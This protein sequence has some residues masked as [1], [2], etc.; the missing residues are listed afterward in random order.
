[1]IKS[2]QHIN[3]NPSKALIYW[4]LTIVSLIWNLSLAQNIH[5]SHEELLKSNLSPY[6]NPTPEISTSDTSKANVDSLFYWK[7]TTGY[8]NVAIDPGDI[9]A[10]I[11][12]AD[13]EYEIFAWYPYWFPDYHKKFDFS[14]VNTVSYF[15]YRFYPESGKKKTS[16]DW[17]STPMV[18]KAKAAGCKVLL[19]VSSFGKNSNATFLNNEES[20]STLINELVEE[21][22]LRDADGVC[23]D[24]ENIRYQE[25]DEFADFVKKL[26]N[27]LRRA[28]GDALVYLALPSVDHSVSF[29]LAMN[30]DVDRAVIMAYG[31][32]GS[33]SEPKP[34]A[35]VNS[36]GH[37]LT[38]TVDYYT[39]LIEPSKV[40][41]GLPLYGC[42][43]DVREDSLRGT[44]SEFEGYR[45]LSYINNNLSGPATIDSL[46]K[47]SYIEFPLATD[48]N[49]TRK[50]WFNN[51]ISFYYQIKLAKGKK[52]G[53]IGLWALGFEENCPL[54]WDVIHASLVPPEETLVDSTDLQP[55]IANTW[56]TDFRDYV[57]ESFDGIHEYHSFIVWVLS[58]VV[59]FGLL[60]FIISM[61][62]YRT[63]EFFTTNN[64]LRRASIIIVLLCAVLIIFFLDVGPEPGESSAEEEKSLFDFFQELY[65]I[66]GF[67]LGIVALKVI[68]W[69]MKRKKSRLP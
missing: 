3:S 4:G 9:W 59:M 34:N 11:D 60:G 43:W 12:S 64:F 8:K 42:L 36:D 67:L 15:A 32:A 68:N 23:I 7:N 58:L 52:L 48:L 18:D 40:L 50:I 35:P 49:T 17:L 14:K 28:N 53:G 16:H 6:A 19:T 2:K 22:K 66:V 41:L 61:F 10:N 26:S 55:M 31:Y 69:S 25:K 20:V 63:R 30:Q 39:Q 56:W 13:Q 38:K 47:A 46:S 21:I 45:T 44:T 65:F 51:E 62:D 37:S 33:W 54:L 27:A 57:S 1:M 29:D 5:E 24:F